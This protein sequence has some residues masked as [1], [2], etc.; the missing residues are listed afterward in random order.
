MIE[1]HAEKGKIDGD[2]AAAEPRIELD[3][4]DDL[5]SVRVFCLDEDVGEVKVPMSFDDPTLG[6]PALE[7]IESLA[8]KN[9]RCSSR[10]SGVGSVPG[11]SRCRVRSVPGSRG[12]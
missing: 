11:R 5:E 3:T 7:Q 2:I 12:C 4:V 8:E 9:A 10:S 6:D 1:V